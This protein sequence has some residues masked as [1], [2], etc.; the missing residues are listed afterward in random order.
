MLKKKLLKLHYLLKITDKS[1]KHAL[2]V[3]YALIG[4]IE[5]L[6]LDKGI[7]VD[8]WMEA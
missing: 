5:A 4:P 8:K 2:L 6:L 1:E 7:D 3:I